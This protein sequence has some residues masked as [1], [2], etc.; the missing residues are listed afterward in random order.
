MSFIKLINNIPVY[1]TIREALRWGGKFGISGAHIHKV[2]NRPVYMA[3]KTHAEVN[4]AL[5]RVKKIKKNELHNS[6]Q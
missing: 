4:K 3:G 5:E 2:N 6:K 1:T